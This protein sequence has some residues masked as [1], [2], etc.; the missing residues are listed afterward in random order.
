MRGDGGYGKASQRRWTPKE[1]KG[2]DLPGGLVIQSWHCS[3]HSTGQLYIEDGMSYI[4][5]LLVYFTEK[6]VWLAHFIVFLCGQ[7][8]CHNPIQMAALTWEPPKQWDSFLTWSFSWGCGLTYKTCYWPCACGKLGSKLLSLTCGVFQWRLCSWLWSC[9]GWQ[10]P[11]TGLQSMRVTGPGPGRLVSGPC[12]GNG[13][14]NDDDLIMN[15]HEILGWVAKSY[16]CEL[17]WTCCPQP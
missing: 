8:I 5:V 7:L 10:Q 2:N 9:V 16:S 4:H 11:K 15:F 1:L 6:S 12:C 14:L 13:W 17:V 3:W